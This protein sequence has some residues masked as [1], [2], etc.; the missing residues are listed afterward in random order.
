M[1][2]LVSIVVFLVSKFV[3][4]L[5]GL[6]DLLIIGIH[7]VHKGLMLFDGVL[8]LLKWCLYVHGSMYNVSI[9]VKSLYRYVSIFH[10]ANTNYMAHTSSANTFYK[11]NL[12]WIHAHILRPYIASFNLVFSQQIQTYLSW[13]CSPGNR[14][15]THTYIANTN[16]FS[17]QSIHLSIT[18]VQ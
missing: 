6:V 12:Q 16:I 17:V 3:S 11:I 5:Y 1:T 10:R 8:S 13:S 14:S 4:V 15:N 7:C 9:E 2:D 18:S